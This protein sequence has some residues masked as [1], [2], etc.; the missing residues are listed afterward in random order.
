[1]PDRTEQ[2]QDRP[3]NKGV[4]Q[5]TRSPDRVGARTAGT[6]PPIGQDAERGQTSHP[7]P[8]DDAGVPSDDGLAREEQKARAQA[9]ERQ[10]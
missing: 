8:D 5:Q 9:H 1:M 10:S 7:A 3:G 4:E 6:S 2:T